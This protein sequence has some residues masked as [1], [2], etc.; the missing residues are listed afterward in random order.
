MQEQTA[1]I[2]MGQIVQER[3]DP[4]CW[5]APSR[6]F[7]LD[8][9]GA[10]VSQKLGTQRTRDVAGQIQDPYSFRRLRRQRS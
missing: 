2:G 6:G 1:A 10:V 3:G 9:V 8:D 4:S 5:I 7:N